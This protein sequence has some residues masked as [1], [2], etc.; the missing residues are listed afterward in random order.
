MEDGEGVMKIESDYV[1]ASCLITSS[2]GSVS[3]DTGESPKLATIELLPD[4]H[5]GSIDRFSSIPFFVAR[6][7]KICNPPSSTCFLSRVHRHERN[8]IGV[9]RR[10]RYWFSIVGIINEK[11]DDP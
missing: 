3:F 7:E 2:T 11:A 9:I 10:R 8:I 1:Q 5:E 4:V 6:D